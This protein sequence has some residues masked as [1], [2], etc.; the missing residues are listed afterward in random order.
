MGQNYEYNT[1]KNFFN[2]L[3]NVV[4]IFFRDLNFTKRNFSLVPKTTKEKG[5]A[6]KDIALAKN[7]FGCNAYN[8]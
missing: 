3:C 2:K 5:S 4:C 8:T 6:W 7:D 1:N